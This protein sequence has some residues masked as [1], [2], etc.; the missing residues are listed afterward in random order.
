MASNRALPARSQGALPLGNRD[1]GATLNAQCSASRMRACSP[2]VPWPASRKSPWRHCAPPGSNR[3]CST[4]PGEVTCFLLSLPW[5]AGWL[6]DWLTGWLAA[7]LAAWLAY[8]FT[9]HPFLS[10]RKQKKT[11]VKSLWGLWWYDLLVV[12][13]VPHSQ[14]P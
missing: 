8:H 4:R 6:A 13:D 14:R 10:F 1:D 2:G 3:P 11:K 12:G 9:Y 7:W 5:L